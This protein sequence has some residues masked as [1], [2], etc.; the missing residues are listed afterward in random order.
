M[1]FSSYISLLLVWKFSIE[2]Q[3]IY[4]WSA[5]F[6]IS[7]QFSNFKRYNDLFEWQI[8]IWRA[9]FKIQQNFVLDCINS[10]LLWVRLH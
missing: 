9:T 3:Q 5:Q 2:I 6:M 1:Q 8:D 7:A 4:N 10:I